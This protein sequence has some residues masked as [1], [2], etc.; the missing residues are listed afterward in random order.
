M[1]DTEP[2]KIAVAYAAEE[3][4]HTGPRP[5]LE[6]IIRKAAE[7]PRPFDVVLVYSRKVLGSPEDAQATLSRLE[8]HGVEVI[9]AEDH[10]PEGGETQGAPPPAEDPWNH[11]FMA[12]LHR[13]GVM[14]QPNPETAP[15]AEA[16]EDNT[17]RAIISADQARPL[18]LALEPPPAAERRSLDWPTAGALYIE[19]DEPVPLLEDGATPGMLAH[20]F[21]LTAGQEPRKLVFT[22]TQEDQPLLQCV[23]Y[24]RR[25]GRAWASPEHEEL[26]PEE[27]EAAAALA[28]RLMCYLG[29]A[30]TRLQKLENSRWHLVHAD[31]QTVR[32]LAELPTPDHPGGPRVP[33]RPGPKDYRPSQHMHLLT[34][35]SRLL[36]WMKRHP[37]PPGPDGEQENRERRMVTQQI[38]DQRSHRMLIDH[39]QMEALIASDR[40]VPPE[41][42][43]ELRWPFDEL[44]YIEPDGA[45]PLE[46]DTEHGALLQGIGVA[47]STDTREVTMAITRGG[48]LEAHTFVVKTSQGT[49]GGLTAWGLTDQPETGA[50]ISRL[51]AF[52]TARGIEI[53]GARLSRQERKLLTRRSIPNPWHIIQVKPTTSQQGPPEGEITGADDGYQWDVIGH[54][55]YGR[56][57]LAD[58]SHRITK[59]W[60]RPHRRGLRHQRYIPGTRYYRGRHG[61]DPTPP[62]EDS[63]AAC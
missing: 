36:R 19:Y 33:P 44:I 28:G 51:L 62:A 25:T 34:S 6:E 47:G 21:L 5:K 37:A 17:L 9:F 60:V 55:R 15:L 42:V 46:P 52:M 23:M 41:A 56:H 8:E 2:R 43:A 14:E 39:R 12:Y 7:I 1:P 24:D 54:V 13:L 50:F 31:M 32:R 57:R 53:V 20:G 4:G 22:F 45:V 59:E 3:Y 48:T 29:A 16:T 49:A 61:A 38:T 26:P 27:A 30:G 10:Q 11:G 40:V 35:K 63:D 58:G 18:V